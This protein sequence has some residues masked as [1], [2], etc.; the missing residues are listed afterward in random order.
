M[1]SGFHDRRWRRLTHIHPHVS[2]D[3]FLR[4]FNGFGGHELMRA[5]EKKSKI[6]YKCLNQITE[7]C[8]RISTATPEAFMPAR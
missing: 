8:F 3:T 1:G 7:Y 2:R 5:L 4:F 6:T